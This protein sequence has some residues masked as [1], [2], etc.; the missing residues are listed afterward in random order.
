M[1]EIRQL[2]Y[3][4]YQPVIKKYPLSIVLDN[5][6]SPHNMG[7]ILRIADTLG[8][9]E[10]IATGTTPMPPSK[11]ISRAARGA[12]R[13]VNCRYENDILPVLNAYQLRGYTLVA[14]E[15]TNTSIDLKNVDFNQYE[16]I[17][18]VAGGEKAGVSEAI[19]NRVD[20][21]VHIPTMGYSLSM[22]VATSVAIA[23]YEMTKH[24][25]LI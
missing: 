13:H 11:L 23:V 8:V 17:I 22:N 10:V 14:L 16:K 18:L 24:L 15:I 1:P 5:L 4:D 21:V 6:D 12:E 25:D 9:E 19:L 3:I 2:K 7:M 20:T